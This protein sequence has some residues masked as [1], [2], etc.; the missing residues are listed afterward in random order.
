MISQTDAPPAIT[1]GLNLSGNE[2]SPIT[3]SGL[4]VG[5]NPLTYQWNFG[6]G[7][8]A[9]GSLNP[10]HTYMPYGVYTAT[11]T[12][13]DADGLS[14]Q[15]SLTATINV[16]P[17]T[18]SL[19]APSTGS[20]GN[21]HRLLR[22]CDRRQPGCAGGRLHLPMELRRRDD[23]DR[24]QRDPYLRAGRPLHGHRLGDRLMMARSERRRQQVNVYRAGHPGNTTATY[25]NLTAPNSPISGVGIPSGSFTVGLPNGR[26][27]SS[28]V[29][30]TPNDGG[31]GG[32]FTPASVVLSDAS[33]TAT[34][35][36]TAAKAGTITIATTDNGGLNNP[37]SGDLHGPESGHDLHAL[38][39]EFRHRRQRSHIHAH[40]RNRLAHQSCPAH[41]VGLEW[42][43]GHSVPAR[44]H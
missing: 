18:V 43:M 16:V 4:A 7:T 33:P 9:S 15:S 40:A 21:P 30:V 14:S 20:T 39:T 44:S 5:T 19:S 27:V 3:F 32:T 36:Y 12:V 10:T 17:P 31:A 22:L 42:R 29:T 1:A 28:P 8:T 11:L 37:P 23:R 25:Y 34:F 24:F 38:W 41:T 6:D 26:F 2:G 35:T 13:T